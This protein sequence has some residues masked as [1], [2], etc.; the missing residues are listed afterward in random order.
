MSSE[1]CLLV[2]SM[3]LWFRLLSY[4][5][6]IATI[7]LSCTVMEIW[8][9]KDNGVTTLIFWGHVTSSVTWPFDSRLGIFYRRSI[10][11][12]HCDHASIVHR[13]RVINVGL[14][15]KFIHLLTA[16]FTDLP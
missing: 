4:G 8:R 16:T 15:N 5:W 1:A 7:R 12:V 3:Y 10:L 9:L 13:Y 14:Q 6:P 2:F 11:M